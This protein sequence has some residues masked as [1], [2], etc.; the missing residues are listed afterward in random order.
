MWWFEAQTKTLEKK[1]SFFSK[2]MKNGFG[3]SCTKFL[4][5]FVGLVWLN[6]MTLAWD[7]TLG[8]KYPIWAG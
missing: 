4:Y 2:R 5:V 1:E 7:D 6:L 8:N 3:K